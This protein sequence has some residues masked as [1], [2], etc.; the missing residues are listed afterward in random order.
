MFRAAGAV[1]QPHVCS[2][3]V[4]TLRRA[5]D[6]CVCAPPPVT[7]IAGE[8]PGSWQW[9]ADAVQLFLPTRGLGLGGR[10]FN[11]HAP[12]CSADLLVLFCFV[13]K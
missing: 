4:G 8:P 12:V 9:A 11:R 5:R 1:R 6:A 10:A 13:F 7:V 3:E 2:P